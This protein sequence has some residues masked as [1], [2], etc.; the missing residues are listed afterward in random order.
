M[1]GEG[2]DR[3]RLRFYA[4]SWYIIMNMGHILFKKIKA[5]QEKEKIEEINKNAIHITQRNYKL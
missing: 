4:S 1:M 5:L 3:H 2:I